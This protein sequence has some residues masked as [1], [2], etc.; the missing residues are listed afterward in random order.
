MAGP[1]TGVN[2]LEFS[3]VIAAPFGGQALADMGASVLKVEPPEG[4]S[5][6]L[7]LP[8]SPLESKTFQCLNRGKDSIALRLNLPE[9]QKIVHQLIPETDVVLIN[10]RP[11]VPKK[12]NIDYESLAAIRPDLIYVDLTAF[13]RQGPWALR[14]GYDGAVQAVSGLM[15]AEGKTRPGEGSP[16]TISST[17]VADFSSGIAMADAVTTAL[18]HR[19][20]TGEGQMVECSLLATALNLQL[21]VIMEHP[22]ADGKRNA[23]RDVRQ[24]RAGQGASFQELLDIRREAIGFEK[25]FQ[26][27]SEDNFFHRPFLTRDGVL[28]VAAETEGQQEAMRKLFSLSPKPS[29]DEIE[30]MISTIGNSDSST[31]MSM[32]IDAGIP[33]A[34]AHYPEEMINDETVL[35]NKWLM[36]LHHDVTGPQ[37]QMKQVPLI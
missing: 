14:P 29:Q 5:W 34:P 13:G 30:Q 10:Y 9:G 18:Y 27:E 16:M 7:Q 37:Q 21:P 2:V 25:G 36:E 19:Q 35:A 28:V 22:L 23:A 6:R 4:D 24:R 33:T 32:L 31:I 26:K 20:M 11:D 3:Q 8:F 17:A 12:F 15:A 1:L